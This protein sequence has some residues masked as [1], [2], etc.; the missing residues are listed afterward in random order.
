MR[1]RSFECE[2]W[3]PRPR[4]E[5]FA[6]FADAANLD[7]ITPGWLR[8]R[9]VTPAPIVMG[10]NVLIEHRLRL[11]G[12]PIRWQSR[13]DVWEPPSRF[14]DEQVSGPYRLWVHEH[15]FETHDGGTQIR[16]RVRYAVPFDLIAHRF[17]RREVER[18]FAYRREM[19]RQKFEAA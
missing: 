9:T 5:V 14:V 13:I 11:Y 18:I 2:Q 16:D 17:V 7:A 6:F 8:F 10:E 15:I 3:L 19:L 1:V 4:E 12:I